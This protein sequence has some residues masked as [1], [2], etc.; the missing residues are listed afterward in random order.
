MP[1]TAHR[2]TFAR[3]HLPPREQWPELIFNRPELAYPHRLNC[4]AALLDDRVAQGHGE[5]PALWSL[6]D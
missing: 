3:D 6:V 1:D 2:D 4:A 5:R